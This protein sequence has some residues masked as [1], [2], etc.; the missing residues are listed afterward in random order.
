M[1]TIND[2]HLVCNGGG[3]GT[4]RKEKRYILVIHVCKIFYQ[5]RSFCFSFCSLNEVHVLYVCSPVVTSW[6]SVLTFII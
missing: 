3:S 1:S 2:H 6:S 4:A 5:L